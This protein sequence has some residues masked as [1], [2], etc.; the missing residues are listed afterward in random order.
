M[1]DAWFQRGHVKRHFDDRTP[2]VFLPEDGSRRILS[3]GSDPDQFDETGD[4]G[5]YAR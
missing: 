4:G 2:P 1:P 3:V 5:M